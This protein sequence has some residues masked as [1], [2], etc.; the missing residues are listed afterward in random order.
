MLSCVPIRNH[1]EKLPHADRR[2]HASSS[3]VE[4]S[5]LA[6]ERKLLCVADCHAA[7]SF[8]HVCGMM[9]VYRTRTLARQTPLCWS[10]CCYLTRLY[11]RMQEKIRYIQF[12]SQNMHFDFA[13]SIWKIPRCSSRAPWPYSSMRSNSSLPT[14]Q[15]GHVKSSGSSSTYSM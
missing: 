2:H 8:P 13:I 12:S 1:I 3:Q 7:C 14:P 9:P 11:G 4:S 6:S 5:A 10:D 15:M